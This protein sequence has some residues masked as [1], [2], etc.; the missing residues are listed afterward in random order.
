MFWT[1]SDSSA[2]VHRST[3]SSNVS[4]R[5]GRHVCSA[6]ERSK[7]LFLSKAPGYSTSIS[8]RLQP[9]FRKR[10]K[11]GDKMQFVDLGSG[12]GRV[13]FRAAQEKLFH[14]CIGYEINPLLHLLGLGRRF[15][16]PKLW[17]STGFQL[18]DIWN[19]DL[20]KADVVAVVS[21]VYSLL[22]SGSHPHSHRFQCSLKYGLGPIMQ[23]LGVKL[24]NELKPG[25]FSFH[26][27]FP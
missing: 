1:L 2:V 18:A 21:E 10:I 15:V 8:F 7:W 20:A 4:K 14:R 24:K 6:K 13:I 17:S 26:F 11:Q 5:Y 9:H 12:D 22:C 25:K 23:D 19:V 3:L 27:W 16:Q